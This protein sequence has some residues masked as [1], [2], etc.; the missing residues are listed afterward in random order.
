[1]ALA[2]K[3]LSA[4]GSL[5]R[6]K[7][8][9]GIHHRLFFINLAVT[10]SLLALLA[11]SPLGD[12]L[13]GLV[14]PFSDPWLQ[15]GIY[16]LLFSGFFLIVDLPLSFYSG[17]T[18][19][20]R[21]SL[22]NHTVKSW[23]LDECK[24]S[25][26]SFAI[27]LLLLE[28]FYFL[29]R[30]FPQEW[31]WIAWAVYLAFT[32]FFSKIVPLWIIPLFYKY[33]PIE[34][35]GLKE[36]VRRLGEAN[37]LHIRNFFSL[38]LSRT[39]KKANAMFTGL[40][41]SKRVV[42]ADTLI[43]N[44]TEDEIETVLAHEIGHFKRKHILNGIIRGSVISF[45]LFYLCARFLEARSL[46]AGLSAADPIFFPELALLVWLI[47]V[48]SGP[49]SN[50]ISRRHEREADAFALEATGKSEAFIS[51]FEKLGRQNLADPE[52]NP[53]IERLLYSH[54]SISKRIA[55]ARNF[56]PNP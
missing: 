36:R 26:L 21:F 15:L 30:S 48:A 46:G 53:W 7:K 8:Y 19:E 43:Q 29:I 25:L 35:E 50:W 55:F 51:A 49:F 6:A 33:G 54:P 2:E 9:Q 37:G 52:P 22:S 34:S 44:F 4:L 1:M 45:V 5:E 41:K 13:R 23:A 14:G 12:R 10:G 56:R 16:F 32:L 42:L 18:I 27:A 20:T 11:L 28:V 40:G 17:F 47:S 39:T 24:K 38:N 3:D 31:W